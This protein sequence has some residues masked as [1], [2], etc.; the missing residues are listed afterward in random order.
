MVAPI[1][2]IVAH[3]SEE[4]HR[5]TIEIGVDVVYPEPDAPAVFPTST[6]VIRLVQLE[7][8][9]RVQRDRADI[10]E[11]ERANLGARIRSW[12]AIEMSLRNTLRN[13]RMTCARIER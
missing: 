5:D 10:A 3:S 8:E 11:A 1:I 6:I 12:E 7:G 9:L 4:S 2:S 13:E